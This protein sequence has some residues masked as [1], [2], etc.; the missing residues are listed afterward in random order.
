MP[1]EI[2][3]ATGVSS[4]VLGDGEVTFPLLLERLSRGE[5][6]DDLAGIALLAAG[7]FRVNPPV[8]TGS[9]IDCIAPDYQRWIDVG[10]MGSH[11][12]T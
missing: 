11:L 10:G 12:H 8:S 6:F 2:L 4:A 3:R 9:S 5:P 1:E 7:E